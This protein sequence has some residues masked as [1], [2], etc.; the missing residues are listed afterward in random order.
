MG[1][2]TQETST[3]NLTRHTHARY[4]HERH[5]QGINTRDTH[6][7]GAE[8]GSIEATLLGEGNGDQQRGSAT[9]FCIY[10]HFFPRATLPRD[11]HARHPCATLSK[12]IPQATLFWGNAPWGRTLGATRGRLSLRTHTQETDR[13]GPRA[14]HRTASPRGTPPLR[15]TPRGHKR[16]HKRAEPD[17]ANIFTTFS[18][19]N[20]HEDQHTQSNTPHGS[21]PMR[22]Y[23]PKDRHTLGSTQKGDFLIPRGAASG[24]GWGSP[25]DPPA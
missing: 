1:Q 17:I 7:R 2:H 8:P 22:I 12:G 25:L 14:A 15:G 3:R 21:T 10:F 19:G 23:T 5:S 4:T 16:L 18:R 11:T 9:T 24:E 6:A 13:E 20:T